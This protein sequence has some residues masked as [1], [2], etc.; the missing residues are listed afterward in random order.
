MLYFEFSRYIQFWR[1]EKLMVF[2][3]IG[4]LLGFLVG[5]TCNKPI[6]DLDEPVKTNLLLLLGFP[7][8]RDNYSKKEKR[9]CAK[10]EKSHVTKLRPF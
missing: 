9:Y 5:I 1:R 3:I 2:I 8:K 6:Q 7:G 10:Y 4:V